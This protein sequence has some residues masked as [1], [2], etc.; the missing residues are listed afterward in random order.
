MR[1]A[2]RAERASGAVRLGAGPS[3]FCAI[4]A[5]ASRASPVSSRAPR[6]LA[7]SSVALLR[8]REEL[9]ALPPELERL[10]IATLGELAAV[11]RGAMADRFGRLGLLAHDLAAGNDSPLR[12][13][14]PGELLEETLE[15]EESSSGVQLGRALELLV[16]RL[17][18]RRERDGRTLRVVVLGATLVEGGTWRERMV[19][20]EPLADPLR[21]RLALA[22]RLALLPA[23][24]R[25]PAAERRALRAAARRGRH[26]LGGRRRAPPGAAARGDPPGARDG[27]ARGRAARAARRPRLA[28]ARAPRRARSLRGLMAGVG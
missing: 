20:R 26:A 8:H 10:G 17:L 1:L 28:R 5:A 22:Q 13:R 27:R 21:M 12:P 14:R 11:P 2:P 15:L 6:D 9:A 25:A 3:R 24:G 16:D 19:F 4:V 23:P 18:A 7:A